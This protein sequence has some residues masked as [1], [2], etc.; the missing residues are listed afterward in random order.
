MDFTN[1]FKANLF[2]T[3]E[4][5]FRDKALR[6]FRYQAQYNPVYARFL[7]YLDVLPSEI[8]Q[9]EQIPFIPID[10]FKQHEVLTGK[11]KIEQ[12]FE[13]S[14]TTGQI[15]SKHF[16]A[17][18]A[19][20]ARISREIFQRQYGSLQNYHI[21]ALLPS[22][23]ERKNASLVAMV[24]DFIQLSESPHSGF[25]LDDTTSLV[26]KIKHLSNDSS[27]K[28]L[29]IGVTFALLDL[30]EEQ[31][32][33]LQNTIVMETGGMKGRR[34]ELL[35]EE[36][37]QILQNRF[38]VTTVHSEYGM[39]EL[40]SQAYS[41]GEGIFTPPS[42]LKILIRSVNDPLEHSQ[43]IGKTGGI[44][45]ID[46]ANVDSCAFIATQDLGRLRPDGH[47]EILGRFDHSDLRGCNL[48][49]G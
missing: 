10:F 37:H 41:S 34:K 9:I 14:G 20:Y 36:V 7:N 17:D 24:S 27:R 8:T 46:L 18:L 31:S 48:L 49:V 2:E 29:L 28:I 26:E 40:L 25:Y 44:S 32:L 30:A 42:W 4:Q 45:I 22:Y 23:L 21:L 16:V 15:R 5:N 19:F 39:T 33:D 47:F 12:I 3:N 6:L 11:P 35:R 43:T 1:S 13:S 38:G